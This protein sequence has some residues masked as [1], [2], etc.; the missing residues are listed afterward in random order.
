[1]RETRF[2]CLL[3][4]AALLSAAD[5]PL[6]DAGQEARARAMFAELRCVV[7]SGESVAESQAEV[8][9]DI[10]REVRRRVAANEDDTTIKHYFV[11]RYGETVLMKPLFKPA[12][13]L[14]WFG[15][16]IALSLGVA[17]I[18]AYYFSGR[19]GKKR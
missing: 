16:L 17:I 5:A 9:E 7:C 12:T 1:M 2:L 19:F 18:F 3:G 6:P 14:L 15:P 4:M 8:A 13:Y 10:R 11:S